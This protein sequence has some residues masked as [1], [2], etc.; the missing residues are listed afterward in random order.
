MVNNLST[1]RD[2]PLIVSL[3]EF[4][5]IRLDRSPQWLNEYRSNGGCF[6]LGIQSLEQL[7]DQYGDKMGAAIISACS[8]HVLFNP[9]NI[10]TA[11]KYSDRYGETEIQLKSRSTSQNMGQ[12]TTS[13]NES[14]QKIP[15]LSVDEIMRFPQGRCVITSPGYKSGAEGFIPYPLT[16][17]V[18]QSD[19]KRTQECEALWDSQVRPKL[20]RRVTLSS[21][22]ELTAALHMRV[23]AA[24]EMLPLPPDQQGPAQPQAARSP[25]V[26][27]VTVSNTATTPSVPDLAED[28]IQED[29]DDFNVYSRGSG[30][31]RS[32]SS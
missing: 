7:Y 29:D 27:P 28:F 25:S 3:D 15:I 10:D 14:L 16:I 8:T 32:R 1:K 21:H 24:E 13:W 19:I 17:P 26:G 9:G 5:S 18:P 31:S 30:R 4:P 23:A 2:T 11:K 6:I 20:E 12:R 22:S